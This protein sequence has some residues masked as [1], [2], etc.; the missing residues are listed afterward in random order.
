M[1]LA[2][3]YFGFDLPYAEYWVPLLVGVGM[4]LMVIGFI[5]RVGRRQTA[6]PPPK[7]APKKGLEFDPFVQGSATEQRRALRRGGNPVEVHLRRTESKEGKEPLLCGWV[8]DRSVGGL[9]LLSPQ[10]F[11]PDT[12]WSVL[13]VN[14]TPMTPWVDVEIR[15]CRAVKDGWEIGCQFVKQPPWAVLLLFG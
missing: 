12:F 3:R 8:L 10:E 4:G 2:A 14:A 5:H 1:L 9:C 11:A 7:P 15:S 6:V 13:P